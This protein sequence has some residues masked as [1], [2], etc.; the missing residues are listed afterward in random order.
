[1][2]PG[3]RTAQGYKETIDVLNRFGAMS[4]IEGV[5]ACYHN[6]D[7]EFEAMDGEIP[8]DLMLKE[9]DPELVKFELDLYWTAHAGVNTQAYLNAQPQRFPLC[10]VKDRSGSGEMVDVGEGTIDFPAMFRAGAG[11]QHHFVEHDN[12]RNPMASIRH[13]IAAVKEIRF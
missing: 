9:C 7:F 1:M 6:H 2:P 12:P 11:L 4:S 8:Y 3:T 5:Q 13:S 10:H